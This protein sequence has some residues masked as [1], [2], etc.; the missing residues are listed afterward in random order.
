MIGDLGAAFAGAALTLVGTPFRLHGRHPASG[1]DCVGLV[2]CSLA[3]A[4]REPVAPVG[5]RL[6]ALSVAPLLDFAGR[7]GFVAANDPAR[8][9]DLLLVHPCPLQAHLVILTASGFVH[10]HAGLGR[11][12]HEPRRMSVPWPWPVAARW[13]LTESPT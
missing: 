8:P 9:G 13:R 10:A 6:R 12:V 4:G 5:Y 7:N 2:G 1:L 11:V 3:I